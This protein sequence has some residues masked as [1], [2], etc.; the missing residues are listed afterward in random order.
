M[1][2]PGVPMNNDD[3]KEVIQIGDHVTIRPRGKKRIWTAEFWLD[4]RHRR[5]SLKTRNVK[6][7][8]DRAR[9]LD[10]DIA[11]GVYPATRPKQVAIGLGQAI[12]DYVDFVRAEG[13]R[14]KTIVKYEGVLKRKM[15]PFL[16]AR[17][18]VKASDVSLR[19][20]DQ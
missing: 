5:Q 15:Q 12:D 10:R 14:D 17:E 2:P 8:K 7:A 18:A 19:L 9:V 4:G 1:H 16:E 6:I 11:L 20:I 13:A 3:E